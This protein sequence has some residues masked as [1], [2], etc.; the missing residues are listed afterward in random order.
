MQI[1]CDFSKRFFT[2]LNEARGVVLDK[3]RILKTKNTKCLSY[4]ERKLVAVVLLLLCSVL[5]VQIG[6]GSF[7]VFILSILFLLAAALHYIFAILMTLSFYGIK[8][9]AKFKNSVLIDERG[10]SDVSYFGILMLFR[11]EKIQAVVI[12]KYTVVILTNTP[13]YFYFPI[14]KKKEIVTAMKKYGHEDLI[15]K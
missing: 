15:I 13:C 1:S 8:K 14:A 12:K 7:Q 5:V 2:C 11:W 4:F 6:N 9:K 10:L 3:K